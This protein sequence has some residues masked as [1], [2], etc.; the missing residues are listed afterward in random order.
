MVQKYEF[1]VSRSTVYRGF[2]GGWARFSGVGGCFHFSRLCL[3]VVSWFVSPTSWELV[4]SKERWSKNLFKF[5]N[6]ILFDQVL[7]RL[8]PVCC[9][10][11]IRQIARYLPHHTN[12]NASKTHPKSAHDKFKTVSETNRLQVGI[13]AYGRFAGGR[14]G[15][16]LD[17]KAGSALNDLWQVEEGCLD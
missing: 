7:L 17:E 2:F 12:G 3:S 11:S 6:K 13:I 14:S 8:F 1:S 15:H 5:A 10:D 9:S 4:R 16:H